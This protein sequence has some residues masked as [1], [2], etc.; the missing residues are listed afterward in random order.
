[1]STEVR[2]RAG[3]V[4]ILSVHACTTVRLGLR[5][6]G[7]MNVYVRHLA[8]ELAGQ[9]IA[10]DVFTRRHDHHD[11]KVVE[12]VPGAR[13]VHIDAGP[14]D[15]SKEALPRYLPLFEKELLSFAASQGLRYDAVHSH[16]W[17][18]G[19]VGMALARRWGVPHVATFHTLAVV[20]AMAGVGGHEPAR[21]QRMEERIAA[22]ADAVIVSA[23]LERDLLVGRYGPDE[24]Q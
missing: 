11:P 15:S 16:Y 8:Q 21:R 12:M 6:S 24:A 20:K 2:P 1:M 9:G 23:P 13:L 19:V 4:A 22:T 5:D 3:R 17:L 14:P 10:V 18:S 7:G